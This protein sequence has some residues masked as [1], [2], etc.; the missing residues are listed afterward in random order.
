MCFT[1]SAAAAPAQA[2]AP[3]LP[4][5]PLSCSL[6]RRE[7]AR[8]NDAAWRAESEARRREVD[9]LRTQLRALAA[10]A[11]S[12]VTVEGA[13][14]GAAAQDVAGAA[15]VDW[16]A[17]D[18]VFTRAAAPDTRGEV[19]SAFTCPLTME[20]YRDPVTSASGHTYERAALV[21]HLAKVGLGA[22]EKWG[23]TAPAGVMGL[24]GA[25]MPCSCR[26]LGLEEQ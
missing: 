11:G 21:E 13:W 5:P 7:L 22:G 23:D 19:P 20:V 14:A 3:L 15:G 4:A 8:A 12:C 1:G 26:A 17:L 10:V 2:H 25:S 6:L 18:R 24:V 9:V 16:A